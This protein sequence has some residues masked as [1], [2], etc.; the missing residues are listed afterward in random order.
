MCKSSMEDS[1]L[2]NCMEKIKHS[3]ENG[4]GQAQ[5]VCRYTNM[6]S[7]AVCP[8]VMFMPR[9]RRFRTL[10]LNALSG[11][12]FITPYNFQNKPE[13]VFCKQ[14]KVGWKHL[15]F[16][17]RKRS[18]GC[19]LTKKWENKLYELSKPDGDSHKAKC[20][21]KV[22][23]NSLET[24]REILKLGNS[25]KLLDFAY[26]FSSHENL[27]Q[28]PLRFIQVLNCIGEITGAELYSVQQEW[29]DKLASLHAD[30]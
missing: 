9:R 29:I 13:C 24:L 8:L 3:T 23:T 20:L 30:L 19:K 22:A 18:R 17:C 16:D 12:D 5:H 10:F 15:L 21:A 6:K 14:K 26:G 28:K 25:E 4:S 1:D 7:P 27:V 2:L 11:C